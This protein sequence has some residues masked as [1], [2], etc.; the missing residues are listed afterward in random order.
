MEVDMSQ[1]SEH[2]DHFSL[3]K[4]KVR[5][6]RILVLALELSLKDVFADFSHLLG[7]ARLRLGSF[8]GVP[9]KL[10]EVKGR[11]VL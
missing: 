11:R 9:L 1:D 10:S 8:V 2:P 4:L 7:V 3:A 5:D 6:L